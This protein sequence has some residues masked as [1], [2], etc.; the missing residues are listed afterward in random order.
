VEGAIAAAVQ[1]RIGGSIQQVISEARGALTPKSTHLNITVP[2]T[3]QTQEHTSDKNHL[4]IQLTVKNMLGLHARPAARFVQTA[5]KFP[6]E[7][8]LVSNLTTKTGQ[9]NAKSINSV[10][11]LGVRQGHQIEVTASGPNARAALDAIKI[12]AENNFGDQEESAVS[13]SIQSTSDISSSDETSYLAGIAA[14]G[15]IALGPAFLYHPAPPEIPQHQ[16]EDAEQEWEKLLEGIAKTRDEIE[17]DRKSA[18]SRTNHNTAA[19]FEAHLMFLEDEA[20]LSPT[21]EK[22]FKEKQNAALAWQTS[23]E[24]ISAGFSTLEDSYLQA[25]GKDV[26]DV[27]RQVL[28]HLLG[29]NHAKF[30]MDKPG[31]LIAADLTPAETSHFEPATVL[32]ICTAAGGPTS[33]TAILARELDIPAVVGLGNGVLALRDGQQIILDGESGKVFVDPESE[34]VNQYS[35]KAEALQQTKNKARLE[36]AA[37]AITRDGRTVEIAAN[38]GSVAGAQ[39]AVESGAEGVGL[40]R[41]EFLFLNRTTAPDEEEQYQAYRAVAKILDGRPLIIRTLDAG[42]DKSIPYLNVEPE[43]NPFLGWRAIRLCLAQP[44]LF[45][46]Q[47]RAILRV[48]SEYPVKVMFPMIAT[49]DELH[50]AKS[51]LEEA[52]QELLARK[53]AYAEKIETGIMVEIPSV[54]QMADRFACEVDFFSIG[55]NDLTQYT[56]AV[57]RTNPKVASLGDACHPAVLRQIQRVV[58]AAR[59]NNIWVGVCGE[60]AGNPI[61]IPILLGLGISELSMSSPAISRTKEVVRSWTV[62]DAEGLAVKALESDSAE[63]VR[64]L[65]RDENS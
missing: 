39:L 25:R 45:K 8:I 37:R 27:G 59:A 5:G 21:R 13:E 7:T 18:A 48:A 47:L 10:I 32:G 22:V 15:G 29:I 9:V 65:L 12:L 31:I 1:A 44:E 43:S 14:S 36:R 16:I 50:R 2:E 61:A 46:T 11:T 3:S 20:L 6:Q 57:D 60:L 38:I 54:A 56:F 41:T 30:V 4:A 58:E 64:A 63:A 24:K 34:L 42:G 49:L 33:H 23:V 55:T 28:L 53:D 51:L 26:E 62:A 52:K 40:F 35:I 19:I 17:A